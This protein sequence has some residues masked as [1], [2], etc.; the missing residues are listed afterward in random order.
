MSD[1]DFYKKYT[2]LENH[3]VENASFDDCM[4][5]TYDKELEFIKD[6]P[7]TKV[8]TIVAEDDL[9]IVIAG[10]HIVN[11]LG[12]FVSKES[13]ENEDETYLFHDEKD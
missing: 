13:W 6:Q 1:D 2:L 7:N 10:G 5:E 4:F 12:Y 8:W 9:M 3:L 11:R